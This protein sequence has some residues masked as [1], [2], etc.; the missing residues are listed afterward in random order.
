MQNALVTSIQCRA[1]KEFPSGHESLLQKA[2]LLYLEGSLY[3][4]LRRESPGREN[5][6]STPASAD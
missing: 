4:V 3:L 1:E 2:L 5:F 6:R